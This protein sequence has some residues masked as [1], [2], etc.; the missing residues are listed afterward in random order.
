MADD[1]KPVEPE[2]LALKAPTVEKDADA[3]AIF[4]EVRVMDE[5]DGTIPRTVLSHYIRIKIFTDRG[6]ESQSKIDIVYSRSTRISDIAARTIK[7]DGTVVPVKKED[8]FDRTMAKVGGLKVQVKSFAMPAVEPGAIIEYKWKET[9]NDELANYI[10]LELQRDIPIKFVKYYIKPLSLP[11]FP[12]GMRAQ[13]FHGENT[14]FVKEKDGYYSTT[15][16]NVPAYH[17]EPRMPPEHES[18]AWILVYYSEDKK[19]TPEKFWPNYGKETYEKYKSSM[20]VNDEVRRVATT[21]IGDASAP[22]DKLRRLFEFCRSRIKNANNAASGLTPDEKAKLKENKNPADTLKHEIGNGLDIDLLF[23]ALATAA[24]FDARF[25]RIADRGDSFFTPNFTDYYFLKAFDVAVRVDGQW[26]FFDPA[27]TYVPYGMLRWQEEGQQALICDA[28][29]SIFVP[30]PVSGPE[31]SLEKRTAKLRLSEDGTIE[32][33]VRVEYTGHLST[34]KKRVNEDDSSAEREKNLTESVKNQMSTA[35]LTD[36]KIENAIDPIKPFAY[37]YHVKVPGY[38]Q[39]TGKRLFLQPSFFHHGLSS[40]FP[41]SERKHP[42]YFRYPWS[43][44]DAVTIELPPG[45]A[46]DSADRPAGLQAGKV[47]QYDIYIGVT[48]DGHTLEYKR[49]FFFGTKDSILIYDTKIYSQLK[50]LF[51]EI[52]RRDEHTITLKQTSLASN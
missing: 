8:V 34:A 6:R 27:S 26:R 41:T 4:W 9:R 46:L 3:E 12:Y 16:S 38:A 30:T 47:S 19:L 14:P 7:P 29:E 37:S 33:D 22:E 40:L 25:V 32:G 18:R 15:M 39:R 42:V 49:D 17:E 48:K 2:Q 51:D 10:R 21:V 52:H 23:A 13:T 28:K 5:Y 36:V 20:K 11:D 1:W 24:G 31:K 50:T 35:E 45:F 43:E 44:Q